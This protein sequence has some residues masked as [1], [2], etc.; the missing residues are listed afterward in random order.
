V[1]V[2][3]GNTDVKNTLEFFGF[4]VGSERIVCK[5]TVPG[6]KNCGGFSVIERG[7]GYN[8]T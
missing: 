3:P 6:G 7:Y 2:G 8:A 4:E 5:L 1:C